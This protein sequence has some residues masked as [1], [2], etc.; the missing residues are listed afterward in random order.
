VAV[1]PRQE[2][3]SIMDEAGKQLVL[4]YKCAEQ[5]A[6]YFHVR[7]SDPIADGVQVSNVAR[8]PSPAASAEEQAAEVSPDRW[9]QNGS[10]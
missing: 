3:D 1:G 6:P 7:V 10:H 9:K 5:A 8:L 4:A 2:I